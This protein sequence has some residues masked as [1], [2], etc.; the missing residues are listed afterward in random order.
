M[1]IGPSAHREVVLD[2]LATG[3]DGY[4]PKSMEVSEMVKAFRTVL[5]GHVFVPEVLSASTVELDAHVK[6]RVFGVQHILTS[7]QI[8]VLQLLAEGQSNKQIARTLNLAESTIKVHLNAAFH[9]L[10]VHNRRRALEALVE[11]EGKFYRGD[12]A[13][14]RILKAFRDE[15]RKRMPT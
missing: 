15:E 14:L 5:S 9:A 12:P 11:L 6:S 1:A 10:G 2:T 8:D 7:R 13:L 4:I 3:V